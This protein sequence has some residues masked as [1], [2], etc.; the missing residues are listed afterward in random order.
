MYESDPPEEETLLN[1]AGSPPHF[2]FHPRIEWGDIAGRHSRTIESR[3]IV[4]SSP[5]SGMVVSDPTVSRLH[6]E[7][8][9]REDGLWVRDLG[10]RNGTFVEGVQVTGARIPQ[11]ARVRLGSTDFVVD[12]TAGAKRPVDLWAHDSF[13]ELVGRSASMRE[14]F[15]RLA[16]IA[17]TDTAVFILGETGTGKELAARAIHDAS[18]RAAKPFVVVDCAALPESLLDTELFG[19]TKGAFTGA[20]GAREGAIA[21]ADGGTVFLDEVGELPI[22]MQPKLLRVLES[23]TVRRIG[24][25]AFREVDVRFVS[26]THRDLLRMVNAGEFREDLYFRLSVL[27]VTVPP[28]RDRREDIELLANHFLK[29]SGATGH[30]NAEVVREL[31]ARPW[32]GNVRELRNIIDRVR[33]LGTAEALA[34]PITADSGGMRAPESIPLAPAGSTAA[35]TAPARQCSPPATDDP[36][37]F[38]QPYRDFRE[39]WI[40]AGE[41][42]YVR[43]LL[44]RN[45][46]NVATAAKWAGVDRTYIYRLLRKHEV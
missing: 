4:G 46:R 35:A 3:V 41:R 40:D 2:R 44:E 32:R 17:P 34:L 45:N 19:H 36:A 11:G 30:L 38:D 5:E 42:E 24:E 23:R 15:A 37:I 31:V 6:A 12:Y 9:A 22:P 8:E 20:A 39:A 13:G 21:A 18:P 1:P 43:R 14:L 10:S 33:A 25:T 16:K 29:K 7:L 27:P 26:A 28:L